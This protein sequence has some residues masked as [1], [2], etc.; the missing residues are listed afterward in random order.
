MIQQNSLSFPVYLL[1]SCQY[2]SKAFTLKYFHSKSFTD[3]L[4]LNAF[5]LFRILYVSEILLHFM[6]LSSCFCHSNTFSF[7]VIYWFLAFK[8]FPSI[9]N[10]L[11]FRNSFTFH[12]F[13]LQSYLLVSCIF[14]FLCNRIFIHAIW[15]R[16]SL[17]DHVIR[18]F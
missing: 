18:S 9:S 12:A 16:T 17:L 11:H 8:R 13:I 15:F 2:H 10:P 6:F 3:F 7:K 1:S 4:H 5:F 14:I